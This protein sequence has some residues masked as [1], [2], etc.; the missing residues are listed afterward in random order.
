MDRNKYI[1]YD[2]QGKVIKEMEEK[3]KS[4]TLDTTGAGVLDVLHV[5]NFIGAIKDGETQNSPIEEGHISTLLCHLGNI[6]QKVGKKLELDV[7][8]GRILNDE[9]AMKE[10]GREYEQGW[11][12]KV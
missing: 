4:A 3:E 7:S 8:N 2:K 9:E 10:W 12:M 11:D 5:K 1:A 6:S